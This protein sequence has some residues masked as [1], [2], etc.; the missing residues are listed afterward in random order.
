MFVGREATKHFNVKTEGFC[1]NICT[2]SKGQ[3]HFFTFGSDIVL[4]KSNLLVD[5][6]ATSYVITDKSNNI[7]FDQNFESGNYFLKLAEQII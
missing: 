6:G 1:Q 5:C 2:S 7:N 4:N 3:T